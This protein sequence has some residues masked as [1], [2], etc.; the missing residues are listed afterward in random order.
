METWG[1]W[2]FSKEN[3]DLLA[4]VLNKFASDQC[5]LDTPKK[6]FLSSLAAS[7]KVCTYYTLLYL[8]ELPNI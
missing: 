3:E 2:T 5:T 6:V 8:N 1:N 4:G 7:S